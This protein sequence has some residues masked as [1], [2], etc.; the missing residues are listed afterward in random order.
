MTC[1]YFILDS[2]NIKTIHIILMF[3]YNT[4]SSK[5]WGQYVFEVFCTQQG[6][7]YLIKN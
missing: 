2:I 3:M 7:N 4:Y 5:V 1:I 6:Y